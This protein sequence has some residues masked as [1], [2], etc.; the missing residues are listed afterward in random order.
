MGYCK[1]RAFEVLEKISF[2]RIAGTKEEY[3]CAEILK[4]ECEKVGIEAVIEEF[5]DARQAAMKAA[6]QENAANKAMNE[7]LT[8]TSLAS[9]AA[10]MEYQ[11][12]MTLPDEE[13]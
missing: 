7:E 1:K 2:E 6:A 13:V 9:I 4:E 3:R 10:S 12:M 11:N 5:E 8:A